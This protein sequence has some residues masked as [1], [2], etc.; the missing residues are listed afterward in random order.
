[1]RLVGLDIRYV[2]QKVD[3][4]GHH[5]KCRYRLRYDRQIPGE[6]LLGK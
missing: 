4:Y 6:D 1:M 2:I 3:R 5:R